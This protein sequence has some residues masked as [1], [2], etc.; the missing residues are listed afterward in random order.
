MP[1]W[2]VSRNLSKWFKTEAFTPV[3]G[4]IALEMTCER[5]KELKAV[6][7]LTRGLFRDGDQRPEREK[8][9]RRKHWHAGGMSRTC[10][11]SLGD[12]SYEVKAG[13]ALKSHLTTTMVTSSLKSSPQKSAAAL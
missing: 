7:M 3:G 6:S 8:D 13:E 5:S 9:L 4:N 12:M 10:S 1:E 11:I 2:S